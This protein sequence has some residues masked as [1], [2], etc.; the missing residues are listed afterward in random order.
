MKDPNPNYAA[1]NWYIDRANDAYRWA[2]WDRLRHIG[3]LDF[4]RT[5]WQVKATTT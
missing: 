3:M 1:L 4:W 5:Q 2:E